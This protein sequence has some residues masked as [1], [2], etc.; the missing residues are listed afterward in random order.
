MHAIHTLNAAVARNL[1]RLLGY[2]F[3]VLARPKGEALPA[4]HG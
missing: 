3:L 1:P 4:V 2:Q